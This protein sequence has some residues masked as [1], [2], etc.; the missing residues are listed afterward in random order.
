MIRTWQNDCC[1]AIEIKVVQPKWEEHATKKTGILR[2][3]YLQNHGS[4]ET[5]I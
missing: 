5:P 4:K 3:T 1:A 2:E